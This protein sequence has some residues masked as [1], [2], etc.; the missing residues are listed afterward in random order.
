L[1][2][3]ESIIHVTFE[4]FRFPWLTT[5]K[6]MG[7]FPASISAIPVLFLIGTVLWILW[8]V[9]TAKAEQQIFHA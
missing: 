7:Y 2:V 9:G 1:G 4:G 5:L 3:L 8:N 6:N